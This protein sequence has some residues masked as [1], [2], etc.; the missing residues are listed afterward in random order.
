MSNHNTLYTPELAARICAL[1][2]EGQGLREICRADG[3]PAPST[4]VL[5]VTSNRDGFA[6]RYA[7]AREAQME[8]FA[9][10]IL[11]IS[12]DG[13]NDWMKRKVGDE[14]ID[15]VDHEHIQR[16]KL[17]VDSRK[18]LMSK[19]APKRYGEKVA[20]TGADGGPIQV[21]ISSEDAGVL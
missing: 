17:R 3:M 20:V 16:S 8:R 6:E 1:I 7:R 12:D 14:V 2:A 19:I 15:V 9:E 18:W 11:E 13:T 10:E 21:N 5:W 4:V